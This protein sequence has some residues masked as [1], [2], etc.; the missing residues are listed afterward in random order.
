MLKIIKNYFRQHFGFS[1]SEIRG[2]LVM[3]PILIALLFA[4]HFLKK[5]YQA[6]SLPKNAKDLAQLQSWYQTTMRQQHPD[7]LSLNGMKIRV[8]DPNKIS[9]KEWHQ[10][11]F[12]KEVVNRIKNYQMAGGVFYDA[13]DLLKIYGISK[14]LVNAYQQFI[15]VQ[16][17]KPK[18]K[19]NWLKKWQNEQ[20]KLPSMSKMVPESIS[21]TM[22]LKSPL[23]L[24][25]TAK[26]KMVRGIGEKLSARIVKFRDALGGFYNKEQLS[27][28]YGLKSEVAEEVL[29]HFEVTGRHIRR[30]DINKIESDSLSKHPYF[31]YRLSNAIVNFRN[32]H[33]LFDNNTDLKKIKILNDSIFQRIEP[34]LNVSGSE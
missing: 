2:I 17:K 8:F 30:I 31:N 7:S 22:R 12:K 20:K 27:E 13:K 15:V 29:N 34:Y 28:V 6:Q 4:P 5:Y 24:A 3:S 25:D 1:R 32:Q 33:G 9:K 21:S 14:R 26:L 16:A 19:K 18:P 10:L 23:N 11:G